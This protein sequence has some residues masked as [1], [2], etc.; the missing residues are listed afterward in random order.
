MDKRIAIP[1]GL[2]LLVALA[3]VGML[4]IFSFTATQ[5]A[6]AS[7]SEITQG[8]GNNVDLAKI[9]EPLKTPL[10]ATAAVTAA[11]VSISPDDPG[12]ASSYTFTFTTVDGVLANGVGKVRILF[13]NDDWT[14][15]FPTTVDPNTMTISAD[16]VTGGGTPTPKGGAAVAPQEVTVDLVGTENDKVEVTILVPDMDPDDNTGGNGIPVGAVV[17]IVFRQAVGIENPAE[18]QSYR[19]RISNYLL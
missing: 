16:S 17:T 19:I 9:V 8:I 3:V 5:P 2:A 13:D 18:G 1:A 6:E 11:S 12:A 15:G 14:P 4:S 7:I 10:Q